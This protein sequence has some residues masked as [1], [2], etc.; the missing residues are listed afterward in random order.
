M[1]M[2]KLLIVGFIGLLAA[3]I[4]LY[5]ALK[6]SESAQEIPTLSPR[7]AAFQNSAEFASLLKKAENYRSEIRQHPDIVQ[8]YVELSWI[9]LQEARITGNHHEYLPKAQWLIEQALRRD[10]QN[11]EATVTKA[12]ILLTLHRFGEARELAEKAVSANSHNA[13]AYGVLTDAYL[14]LGEYEKA[15]QA[16]DKMLGIRPDLRSY[17]RASYLRELH[18][19]REAA[20]QAMRLAADAGVFG[21]EERAWALYQLGNLYLNRGAL[22]TAAF[23]FRGIREERPDYPWALSGEAAVKTASKDY[24]AAIELLVQAIQIS[25]EHAFVEQLAGIYRTMGHSEGEQ[26]MVKKAL[27]AF[28]QHEQEGWNVDLEY[29]RFCT[30]HQVHLPEALQRA[31]REYRRRPANIEALEV[32]AWALHQNE[33]NR[34]ALPLIQHALRLNTPRA[35]LHYRAGMIYHAAGQNELA[36]NYLERALAENPFLG[37]GYAQQARAV[38]ASLPK[39]TSVH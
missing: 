7:S 9:F 5:L 35:E 4:A 22:D 19:Q 31:E 37:G 38:I 18:G 21:Q 12:S 34:E 26:E 15:V 1:Q 32:Y 39:M 6:P 17:T 2:N 28:G 24:P 33:K 36:R 25:P 27:E 20:I 14:E 11:F 23:I 10:P 8:N 13:F 30:E 3:G 16:C 29:A